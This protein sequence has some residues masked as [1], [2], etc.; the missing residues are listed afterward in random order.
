MCSFRKKTIFEVL[1]DFRATTKEIYATLYAVC[2]DDVPLSTCTNNNDRAR[3]C[4]SMYDP[5]F[6]RVKFERLIWKYSLSNIEKNIRTSHPARSSMM[7][8]QF[9]FFSEELIIDRSFSIRISFFS[10]I[11]STEGRVIRKTLN[12]FV[13]S[14]SKVKKTF[15]LK[16][17]FSTPDA[18]KRLLEVKTRVFSKFSL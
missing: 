17:W 18:K 11:P 12:A 13:G 4:Y 9:Y 5:P 7:E 14:G 2:E 1:V 8:I 3:F 15:F 6:R 16:I 10:P